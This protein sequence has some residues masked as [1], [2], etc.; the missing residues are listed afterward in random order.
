MAK[1]AYTNTG[2]TVAH[3][4][5]KSIPPGETREVE[6]S[7]LPSFTTAPTKSAKPEP[8]ANPLAEIL[9]HSVK[10]ITALLPA[11]SDGELAALGEAEQLAAKPRTTLLGAIAEVM[12]ARADK[13]VTNPPGGTP[14]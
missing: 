5:G 1:I 4:G 3:V 13:T 2:N 11:M 8:E 7:M 14:E 12:L 9:A 6:E 10:D